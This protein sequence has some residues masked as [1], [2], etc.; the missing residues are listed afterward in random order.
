MQHCPGTDAGLVGPPCRGWAGCRKGRLSLK[1]KTWM[2]TRVR[3]RCFKVTII[4]G[5]GPTSS[6][7]RCGQVKYTLER[8]MG[9]LRRLGC[10]NRLELLDFIHF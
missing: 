1:N 8:G 7:K 4:P 5:G 10:S 9:F 3:M 6:T 2:G